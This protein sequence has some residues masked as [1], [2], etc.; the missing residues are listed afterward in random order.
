MKRIFAVVPLA[1]VMCAGAKTITVDYAG[2]GEYRTIGEAMKVVT[3]GDIVLVKPG[4]YREEVRIPV[5]GASKDRPTILRSAVRGKAVVKGSEIW[6][7]PWTK[8]G[9]GTKNVWTSPFDKS[10][11]PVW[12][13]SPYMRTI[14][15]ADRDR[16][17]VARPVTNAVV[18][19]ETYL[20]RTIGQIFVDG[21]LL[22]EVTTIR[23]LEGVPDTWMVSMDGEAIW[24]HPAENRAEPNAC[25]IEW[26][27]RNRCIGANRRGLADVVVDGFTVEHCANQ[28]PF[29]QI[30][31][32]DVRSGVRWI[33]ENNTVRYAKSA[34][35]TCGSETWGDWKN[36]E[37]WKDQ[38]FPDMPDADQ[39]LM[40]TRDCEI[41][42]N[43]VTDCGVHGIAAWNPG[44]AKIYCNVIERNN[45]GDYPEFGWEET[46]GIKI[47]GAP[48][49]VANNVIRDNEAY[50]VWFDTGFT[51]VRCTGNFI[52]SNRRG[53]IMFETCVGHALVDNNVIIG[54][55]PD[56]NQYYNGDG[57][58]SHNGSGVTVAHNFIGFNGGAGV[59]F[60]TTYGKNGGMPDGVHTS[61]NRYV[62]NIFCDNAKGDLMIASENK[63]CRGTV[64]DYN[65][66]LRTGGQTS[67]IGTLSPFC[68]TY[69]NQGEN[70]WSNLW[71]QCCSAGLDMG[72]GAW[73]EFGH[74]ME[75][76][77]W[78]KVRGLDL[79]SKV[80]RL[81]QGK[82]A[83]I[84]Y[85]ELSALFKFPMELEDVRVPAI[86]GPL[87]DY[88][89]AEYPAPGTLVRPGPF[90]KFKCAGKPGYYQA[91]VPQVL[92]AAPRNL[93]G[94]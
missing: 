45:F 34:G 63:F 61:S 47:H 40:F 65:L 75:L 51:D 80:V 87:T 35:I 58:Y 10:F 82:A 92:K 50:G 31:A 89:G 17:R 55:R 78:Q 7:N 15:I 19:A 5:G 70:S 28:G 14:S 1:A 53:G 23:E 54:N 36:G 42:Y 11:F 41:R 72:Y 20:P 22:T 43:A 27:V 74:P 2:A 12:T 68:Y 13:N 32:V 57:V 52:A 84:A 44:G 91:L 83:Q 46:A 37:P 56:E 88:L 39:R 4:V 77:V 49:V 48:A 9:D 25:E 60:R 90:Q 24:L 94:E 69:Y 73:M 93:K 85:R 81:T 26:S 16:S 21:A 66:F 30:G 64:S 59:R 76:S 71:Q 8:H 62:N 38:R 3:K 18:D 79:H 6:K 29:P 86:D 67:H 33:V